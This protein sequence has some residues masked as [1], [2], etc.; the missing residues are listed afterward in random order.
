[1]P[2]SPNRLL[3]AQVVHQEPHFGDRSRTE[4]ESAGRLGN[5]FR[6]LARQ[7]LRLQAGAGVGGGAAGA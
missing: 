1:M 5:I 6:E 2:L 4:P 3:S 7:R